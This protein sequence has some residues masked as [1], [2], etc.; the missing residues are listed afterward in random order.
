MLR[1]KTGLS[2]TNAAAKSQANP[3]AKKHDKKNAPDF[4]TSFTSSNIDA[5]AYD[6][7][8]KQLWVRFKGQDVY[9]YFDV[10]IQ[11]YRG[12]WSAPSK[13]HYFWEKI[14]KN[15]HIEYQKLTAALHW[16]PVC[17][18]HLLASKQANVASIMKSFRNKAKLHPEWGE[19]GML[20][21]TFNGKRL[22]FDNFVVDAVGY[23]DKVRVN[24]IDKNSDAVDFSSTQATETEAV[25]QFIIKR[26]TR[27][28]AKHATQQLQAA[29]N[30]NTNIQQASAALLQ[31]YGF[32]KEAM[33]EEDWTLRKGK[34]P[35]D[36][37]IR[38]K[39][40]SLQ[41]TGVTDT[42]LKTRFIDRWADMEI[43]SQNSWDSAVAN[44]LTEILAQALQG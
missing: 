42:K 3:F 26:V 11:I 41:V 4:V 36:N 38:G 39:N 25:V 43:T 7:V 22:E 28:V 8:K 29:S 13:G 10:P 35:D 6:P 15:P 37:E 32:L 34:E 31:L 12:F 27:Y 40:Y 1:I 14:R 17:N 18:L 2:R 23:G 44:L 20:E 21:N 19:P 24:I 33:P 9:T 30:S 5:V 16:Y